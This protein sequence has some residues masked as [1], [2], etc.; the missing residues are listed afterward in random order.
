MSKQAEDLTRIFSGSKEQ[1]ERAIAELAELVPRDL[2]TQAENYLRLAKE[3]L[4]R[5]ETAYR[6]RETQATRDPLTGLFNRNGYKEASGLWLDT[7]EKLYTGSKNHVTGSLSVIDLN[8]FKSV[9]DNYGHETGDTLLTIV[10]KALQETT[11]PDDINIRTKL[12][13]C[14]A[15]TGGDEFVLLL[16]GIPTHSSHITHSGILQRLNKQV[17]TDFSNSH[18]GIYEDNNQLFDNVLS[19]GSALYGKDGTTIEDLSRIAD[20]RLYETKRSR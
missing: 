20:Q 14:G 4:E 16:T 18:R 7:S 2:R 13:E 15:R 12:R 3:G 8:K 9:N 19:M 1:V 11:R 10:A 5:G 6:K 17:A